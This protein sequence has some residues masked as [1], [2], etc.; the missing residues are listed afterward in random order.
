MSNGKEISTPCT[1]RIRVRG[2]LAPNWSDWFYGFTICYQAPDETTLTGQV[3]D[4]SALSGVLSKISELGFFLL[5]V[6]LLQYGDETW[7]TKFKRSES[8]KE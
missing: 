1:Y 3:I 7:Q 8:C 6:D 5:S 4:Q 2:R